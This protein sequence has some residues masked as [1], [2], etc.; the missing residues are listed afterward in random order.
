MY[1]ALINAITSLTSLSC[2]T[3]ASHSGS[4]GVKPLPLLGLQKPSGSGVHQEKLSSKAG[5]T[6]NRQPFPQRE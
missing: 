4:L 6:L 1:K 3:T 5:S 2:T